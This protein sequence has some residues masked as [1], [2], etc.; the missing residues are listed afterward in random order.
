MLKKTE[1]LGVGITDATESEILEYVF[2][3]LSQPMKKG[4]IV[5]PNPEIITHAQ[6]H[7]GFRSILNKAE[8][9]LCDGVGV[10]LAAALLGK[11]LPGRTTGVDLMEAICKE[12]VR[13]GVTIGFLGAG[14][15]VA[16]KTAECLSRKYPGLRVRFVGEEWSDVGI[17][18]YELGIKN[19][20]DEAAEVNG[21]VAKV[22]DVVTDH[23]KGVLRQIDILFVAFGFPKQEE[24]ISQ[25]LERIP[26]R[27]A[28]G[29]GGAFDYIGGRV[30][31]A[32]YLIRAVGLE[33]L[34]RLVVQ[35]WRISRQLRLITF[36]VLVFRERAR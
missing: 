5:T 18:N 11:H 29:V 28:M 15:G 7:S 21:N 26:V 34:F 8:I 27:L 33:W 17:M 25:H 14:P 12:S 6:T 4:Y 32:P 30:P 1:I 13:K 10:L 20:N 9:A 23:E 24:W 19:N 35:P 3:F 16:L 2:S 31:R 22:H 36:L